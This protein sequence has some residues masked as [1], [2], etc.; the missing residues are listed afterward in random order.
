[1]AYPISQVDAFTDKPFRGNPAAVC[2]LAEAAEVDWMQA[3]AAEM[4]LSETAFLH[5]VADGFQLRWFTPAAEVA[6][7]GHATL[8]S[9]HVL[10]SEGHLAPNREARFHT[11]SGL[12]TATQA[13]SWISLNFPAQP[14]EAIELPAPLRQALHLDE[15]TPRYGGQTPTNYLIELPQA[16]Q[17]RSLQPDYALLKTLPRQGVIVT[18]QAD[19]QPYDFISRYFAP[20]VG[21][22][23]D[24]VTGSAHCTLGPYWQGQLQKSALLAY[25][26]SAR[27]GVLKLRCQE[28]TAVSMDHPA[29]VE[30]SGKAVTVLHG[31][32]L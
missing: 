27:G 25:Q 8:A 20:K 23:E 24:P 32:L 18:S 26:A 7:C 9:A 11:R 4:N 14:S 29:R 15:V 22:D 1:M 28:V 19:A 16:E 21:I 30:I 3:V 17:V 12:L 6:L 10:W 2:V 31:Q 5:P 13:G